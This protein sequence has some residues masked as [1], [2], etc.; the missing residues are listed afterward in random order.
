MSTIALYS[1]KVSL[2]SELINDVKTSV[3]NYKTELAT[4][5][6]QTLNVNESM[7]TTLI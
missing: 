3:G 4:L 7:S 2:M 5:S 6:N 1:T